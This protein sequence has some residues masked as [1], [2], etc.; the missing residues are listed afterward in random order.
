VPF[1]TFAKF[2]PI[3]KRYK[4]E[5]ITLE[6]PKKDTIKLQIQVNPKDK[7]SW[8]LRANNEDANFMLQIYTLLY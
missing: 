7:V 8:M 1:G 3:K 2:P 6:N 5:D 4:W